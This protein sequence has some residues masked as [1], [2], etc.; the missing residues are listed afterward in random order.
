MVPKKDSKNKDGLFIPTRQVAAYTSLALS[1]L[2]AVF[3]SGYFFGKKHMADEFVLKV[4][5]DSFADQISASLCALYD[6]EL[7]S[8]FLQQDTAIHS[9]SPL[10]AH[11]EL[12]ADS[13]VEVDRNGVENPE[14]ST[15]Y[16]AQLIGYGTQKAAEQFAQKQKA[17]GICVSVK[18]RESQTA[19]GKKTTWY[20]VV[21][22]PFADRQAL[23][24]LAQRIARDEKI[25]G[26]Q[27]VSC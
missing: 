11:Q 25:E 10:M 7:E 2:G 9:E 24:Q 12:K 1:V 3:M 23:D 13:A 21:T 19:Q 27:V 22:E 6:Q 26:I 5:H 15:S 16:Y 8:D 18:T 4:E 20:Q 14:V 17:K